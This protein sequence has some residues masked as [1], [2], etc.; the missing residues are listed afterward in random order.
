MSVRPYIAEQ[1]KTSDMYWHLKLSCLFGALLLHFK[2]TRL[3]SG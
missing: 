1:A 3:H 2:H